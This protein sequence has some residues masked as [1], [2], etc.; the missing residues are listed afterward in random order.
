MSQVITLNESIIIFNN[1]SDHKKMESKK[2]TTARAEEMDKIGFVDSPQD[3]EE[4]TV[5]E[6]SC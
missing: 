2:S 3:G 4:A 6:G 1:I 5:E